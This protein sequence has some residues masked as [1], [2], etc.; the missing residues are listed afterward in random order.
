MNQFPVSPEKEEQL[1][2]RMTAFGMREADLEETFVRSGGHGGQNVNKTATCVML[3]HRPTGLRVKCQETRQQGLNRFLARKLLL[4]KLEARQKGFVEAERARVEKIRRQ[5]RRRS[6][7]AR[8]RMLADKA[9]QSAKKE[10][11]RQASAE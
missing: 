10:G 7:R 6:R 3:L 8:Q 9:H 5:K 4:D 2:Q 1:A 11:R